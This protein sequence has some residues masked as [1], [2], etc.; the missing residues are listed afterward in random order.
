MRARA[1]GIR[2]TG[3]KECSH[4]KK[5]KPLSEFASS[6]KPQGASSWCKR[7]V[8][9]L[10]LRTKYGIS[11]DQKR[12]LIDDQGGVCGI[13]G[14]GRHVNMQSALD[15]CHESGQPRAVLCRNCN[16]VLGLCDENVRRIE[17]IAEYAREWKQ[18]KLIPGGKAS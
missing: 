8:R 5:V 6:K 3:Q 7:C 10:H 15:H 18:L 9:D 11:L 16:S 2:E 17:G 1:A 12:Q 4:C 14:C 13:R